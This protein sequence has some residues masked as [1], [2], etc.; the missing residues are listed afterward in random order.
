MRRI[1][2]ALLLTAISTVALAQAP[3]RTEL[4]AAGKQVTQALASK[5]YDK[6]A[7]KV[8]K[9]GIVVYYCFPDHSKRWATQKAF[10]QATTSKTSITWLPSMQGDGGMRGAVKMT[11]RELLDIAASVKWSKAKTSYNSSPEM[12]YRTLFVEDLK[13]EHKGSSFVDYTLL[14]QH[15]FQTALILG[16]TRERGSKNLKLTAI[17]FDQFKD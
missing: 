8:G 1:S 17:A 10:R 13:P 3:T 9:E 16:F 2:I 15:E 5:R 4:T 11:L 14:H 12:T 6:L 7:D